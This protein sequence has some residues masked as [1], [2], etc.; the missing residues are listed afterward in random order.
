ME[1]ELDGFCLDSALFLRIL[2]LGKVDFGVFEHFLDVFLQSCLEFLRLGF[3]VLGFWGRLKGK[4]FLDMVLLEMMLQ[5]H[6]Y[7]LVQSL[8]FIWGVL[9]VML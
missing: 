5:L 8:V 2:G 7:F 3:W 4:D 1:F 9:T 6:G